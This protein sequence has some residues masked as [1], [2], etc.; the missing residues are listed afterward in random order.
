ME[1]VSACSAVFGSLVGNAAEVAA[2]VVCP[3]CLCDIFRRIDMFCQVPDFEHKDL[4]LDTGHYIE[5][6]LGIADPDNSLAGHTVGL[7]TRHDHF[8]AHSDARSG[9]YCGSRSVGRWDSGTGHG[10]GVEVS[11]GREVG[12]GMLEDRVAGHTGTVF[13][14][15]A[16]AAAAIAGGCRSWP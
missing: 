9:T 5:A 7:H 12:S 15:E 10:A 13:V 14:A 3:G 16:A 11:S 1:V 8:G 6:A 2:A 4:G